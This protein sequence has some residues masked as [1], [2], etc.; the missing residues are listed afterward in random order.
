MKTSVL[1]VAWVRG[2]RRSRCG[3]PLRGLKGQPHEFSDRFRSRRDF[4]L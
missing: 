4:R 3:A 1:M 2:E